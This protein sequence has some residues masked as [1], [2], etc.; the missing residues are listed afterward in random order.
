MPKEAESTWARF[1]RHPV[2]SSV[3]AA[4]IVAA[5]GATPSVYRFIVDRLDE[6]QKLPS[7]AWWPNRVTYHCYNPGDD[8]YGANH[9]VFNST[10]DNTMVGDKRSFLAAMKE[11]STGSAVDRLRVDVGDRV[12]IRAYFANNADAVL[13]GKGNDV[14]RGVRFKL[15]LPVRSAKNQVVWGIISADNATPRAIGD[16]V[17]LQS[18]RKFLL[19]LVPDSA[20]LINRVHPESQPYRLRPDIISDGVLLGYDRMDGIVGSCYC[21]S[22]WVLATFRVVAA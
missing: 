8:C 1:T 7:T 6:N 10:V 17:M 22:G 9:V 4:A 19:E 14:A 12:I 3:I 2:W 11:G 16:G 21:E 13:T 5:I 15:T 20:V 18:S